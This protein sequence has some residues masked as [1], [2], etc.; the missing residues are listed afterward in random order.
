MINGDIIT[1]LEIDVMQGNEILESFDLAHKYRLPSIV[2]HPS[3]S[4]DALV[5]RGRSKG[6]YKIITPVDWPKGEIFATEKFKGLSLDSLETDGFEIYISQKKSADDIKKEIMSCTEFVK[7]F[8]GEI[9]EIRFVVGSRTKEPDDLK[10]AFEAFRNVK[11]PTLVRDDIVLKTQNY[12]ANA[13]VHNEFKKSI[14]EVISCPLKISGNIETIEMVQSCDF[15]RR[16]GV[17]LQQAKSLIR[18]VNNLGN[19][20]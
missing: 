10:N 5:C 8:L 12:K 14:S 15:A 20:S 19:K 3:L 11:N 13:D 6:N 16:F 7:K 18:D 2:I 17:S 1:R 4:S 9:F